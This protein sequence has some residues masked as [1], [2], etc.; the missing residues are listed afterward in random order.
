MT[1]VFR[2]RSL[3]L[4]AW[5]GGLLFFGFVAQVAF[6]RLDPHAAG[7]V[8]RGSLIALHHIGLIAGAVYFI[9][10]LALLATQRDT[11]PARALELVL[12]VAMLGLTAYS[13]FSVLPR[14][15]RDRWRWTAT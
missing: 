14:M 2:I 11:H 4:A 6:A 12:I 10:T 3:S 8:V 13:Q 1:P 15:E 5:T 7:E 9:F